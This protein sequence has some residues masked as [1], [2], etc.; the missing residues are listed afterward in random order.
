MKKMLIGAAL[1]FILT[2]VGNIKGVIPF[3][4]SLAVL[5]VIGI[6]TVIKIVNFSE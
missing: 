3:G 6:I 4:L 1:L 2:F 5:T